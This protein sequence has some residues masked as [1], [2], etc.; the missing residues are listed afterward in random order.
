[1]S[2]FDNLVDYEE[3]EALQQLFER[4]TDEFKKELAYH[5]LLNTKE[6]VLLVRKILAEGEKVLAL[7]PTATYLFAASACEVI[8][9]DLLFVPLLRG[10]IHERFAVDIVVKSIT[11]MTRDQMEGP[12]ARLLQLLSFVDLDKIAR[13]PKGPNIIAECR[14]LA[15]NR[16][17]IM[18]QGEQV[19]ESRARDALAIATFLLNDPFR[20]L[21]WINSL[22]MVP[23]KD[24]WKDTDR[25]RVII[26]L[27]LAPREAQEE[28]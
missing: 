8:L 2:H 24:D 4:H 1:M 7:S 15:R 27:A 10:L 20:K 26:P 23:E 13:T 6:S 25:L 21:L 16:N 5:A 9:R 14:A 28:P 19:D 11:R 22:Y 17:G 3:Q 18:H 12:L